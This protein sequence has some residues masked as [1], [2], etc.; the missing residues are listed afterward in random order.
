MLLI[1]QNWQMLPENHPSPL[2]T[3]ADRQPVSSLC[4]KGLL[5]AC[6]SA[7][8]ILGT[9]CFVLHSVMRG[10]INPRSK[11]LGGWEGV[12]CCHYLLLGLEP[13]RRWAS[14]PKGGCHLPN[15][16]GWTGPSS[17]L[18]GAACVPPSPRD[19]ESQARDTHWCWGTQRGFRSPAKAS[20]LKQGKTTHL[21]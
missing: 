12:T 16:R 7:A 8:H 3:W 21:S 1:T 14:L 9:G 19:A 2:P 4:H 17:L 11:S 5:L 10:V 13:G 18:A 15:L 6:L 20:L